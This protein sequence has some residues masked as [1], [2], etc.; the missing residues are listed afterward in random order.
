MERDIGGG[1]ELSVE[2]G[3]CF[4]VLILEEM[5]D[6]FPLDFFHHLSHPSEVLLEVRLN[7]LLLP[8]GDDLLDEFPVLPML[9]DPCIRSA[10]TS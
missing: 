2:G 5:V 9:D 6:S 10:L 3:L 8:G 4:K 1:E 7:L